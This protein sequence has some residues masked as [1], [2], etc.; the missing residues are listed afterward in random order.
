MYGIG[1][2]C[3]RL[4]VFDCNVAVGILEVD[5]LLYGEEFVYTYNDL[6]FGL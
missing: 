5:V 4:Y 3:F 6:L 2:F 1:G